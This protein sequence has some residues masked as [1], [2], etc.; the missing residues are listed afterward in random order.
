MIYGILQ[1]TASLNCSS[2]LTDCTEQAETCH[3]LLT[4]VRRTAS[5]IE[6][7]CLS[8]RLHSA[9]AFTVVFD[10]TLYMLPWLVFTKFNSM[11]DQIRMWVFALTAVWFW[12]PFRAARTSPLGQQCQKVLKDIFTQHTGGLYWVPGHA[13]VWGNVITDKLARNFSVQNFVGPE[14]SLGVTRQ[15]IRR[16]IKRWLDNENFA[17]WRGFGSN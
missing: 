4:K 16:Q 2:L 17:R 8:F 7:S 11:V 3:T 12:K 15:N 5:R 6:D 14:P 13:G 1:N 10:H 9:A